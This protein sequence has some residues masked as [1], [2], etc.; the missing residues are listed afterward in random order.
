MK[1]LLAA[2]LTTAAL[3]VAPFSLA[4]KMPTEWDGLQ[5]VSAKK[6]DYAYILPGADF[7]EYTKVMIDPTE[8]A[9][10]KN[11]VR[12]WNNS[13]ADLTMKVSE[14]E[15]R[16]KLAL[17]QSGFEEIFTKAYQD[18][19]YRVETTAAPD[20]L[21]I[22]TAVFNVDVVSPDLMTPG[23]VYSFSREAGG[24]SL[25]IEVRDSMTGAL[26]ARGVD[27]RLAGDDGRATRRTS[28]SNKVDFERLFKTWSKMSVD[29][30]AALKAVPPVTVASN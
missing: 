12:D 13:H 23:R 24:A 7:R 20:V 21:R 27:S 14:K 29:G 10:R 26:L 4:E 19:G 2:C 18:A 11:W 1:V 16:E 22:K 17:V 15:A 3:V 28:V 9:F 5:R 30:L 6:F 8:V 25:M